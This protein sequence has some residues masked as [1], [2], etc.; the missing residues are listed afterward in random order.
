MRLRPLYLFGALLWVLLG[1]QAALA[2]NLTSGDKADPTMALVA[3]ALGAHPSLTALDSQVQGLRSAAS[4]SRQIK[5][6]KLSMEYSNVPW[7]SLALGMSP[8][9]GLQLRLEQTLPALGLNDARE[10]AGEAQAEVMAWKLEETKAM[11]AASLKRAYWSLAH[12]R[13][14]RALTLS[15]IEVTE[16]ILQAADAR[17]RTGYDNQAALLRVKLRLD[18]LK[19]SLG[20]LERDERLLLLALNQSLARPSDQPLATAPLKAAPPLAATSSQALIHE[21]MDRRGALRQLKA[22]KALAQKQG[23]LAQLKG[24]PEVSIWGGYRI[25]SGALSDGGTDFVSVGIG[26]PIPLDVSGARKAEIQAARHRAESAESSY[27]AALL[28]IQAGIDS[29]LAQWTRAQELDATYGED[30]LPLAE[31]SLKSS[32]SA[33]EQGRGSVAQVYDAEETLLDLEGRRLKAQL[34]TNI[35][36]ATL[37]ALIGAI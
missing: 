9:S 6:P 27:D 31:S 29:T 13:A 5:D 21:A 28:T 24:R 33:Y 26:A 7:N 11:L 12:T 37:A 20:D 15:H 16:R 8:M 32:L 30:L 3:E 34:E 22:E 35:H 19:D 2:T 17:Y 14:Q 1:S 4:G 23:D 10:A 25:R 36:A 18:T